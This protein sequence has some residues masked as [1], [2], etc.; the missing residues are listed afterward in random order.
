ME[1]KASQVGVHVARGI[2]LPTLL[3]ERLQYQAAQ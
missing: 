2:C 1:K 3:D